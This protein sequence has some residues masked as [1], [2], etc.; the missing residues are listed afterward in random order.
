MRGLRLT[1]EGSGCLRF[2]YELLSKLLVS[3]LITPIVVPYKTPNITPF[4]EFRLQLIE[5]EPLQDYVAI[6]KDVCSS[7]PRVYIYIYT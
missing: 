3:P 2:T 4:K 1:D 7:G 5:G 6:D